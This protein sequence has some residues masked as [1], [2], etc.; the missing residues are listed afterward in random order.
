MVEWLIDSGANPNLLSTKVYREIPDDI[1][2]PLKPVETRLMAANGDNIATH[3]Q[4]RIDLHLNG[5]TFSVLVIVADIGDT[6]GILGMR[7]LREASCTMEFDT[8]VLSSGGQAWQLVG[9]RE[10]ECF[11]VR[12]VQE[13]RLPP[14]H[15]LAVLGAVQSSRRLP[16]CWEGIM[17]GDESLTE[18]ANVSV[19]RSL[20]SIDG[21]VQGQTR[22][23]LTNWSEDEVV[24]PAGTTV[25]TVQPGKVVVPAQ[26]QVNTV[27]EMEPC[28]ELPEHLE[29]LAADAAE[30]LNKEEAQ[31]VLRL[32][33]KYQHIFA[34]PGGKLG[35]T[36]LVTHTIDT[37]STR[38]IKTPYRPPGFARREIIDENLDKMLEHDV[39][40][41]SSSPWS[42]PVVLVK[43]KDGTTRFCVDLRRLNEVTR[44][45]A[46]PL[47]NINDCL[48]S[49]S[50]AEWFCTLDLAS[51]YWQVKMDDADKEKTAFST[52]RGLYQFR[53]MPFGLTNAPATFMRL[54]ELVLRGLE[55]EQ[56]L[57]YLDDVVAFG[58]TFDACLMHLE[59]VFQRFS[60]A[61]LTLKPSK[62]QLFQREVAFLGHRISGEGVSCDP[63]KLAAV[64]EWPRPCNVSDVR[65][66]LGLANYYKRFVPQ[67]SEVAGPLTSLTEKNTPFIWREECEESFHCLKSALTE[68][69][70]LAYPSTDPADKFILDTDASNFGIGSVLS[71]IQNGTERVIAYGSKAL[72]KSQRNYCT[73]Y[74]ELLA[75]VEFIPH[76]KHFLM[77]RSFVVRTDHSSLRWLMRFKDAEGLVGRWLAKLSNYDFTVEHR[78]GSNHG[79]ADALSRVPAARRRRRCGRP[80]CTDC[81][82]CEVLCHDTFRFRHW[83]SISSSLYVATR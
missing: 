24:L 51:G 50:G 77:G 10:D 63:E 25:A 59:N 4:T 29:T 36:D 7:F 83:H 6:A 73:T 72:S 9:P 26:G 81:V 49:L 37:G 27:H 70:V 5:A 32:L 18:Q 55:W 69:P 46:Y 80:E 19:S 68:A 57:V 79:N 58:K 65:S 31:S 43:K 75:L 39:I 54:M 2:P 45:D 60:Q 62:C 3:G 1:R 41:P 13:V 8:G 71:Q 17:E 22:F 33:V 20:V 82:G 66:F 34:A 38:P 35:T 40:E 44:K 67:F 15:G 30:R 61:G 42:S 56:C 52:H 48:G 47:P 16:I 74:R 78:A 21:A 14:G 11:R 64:R 28:T 12:L 53:K 76:F 23:T